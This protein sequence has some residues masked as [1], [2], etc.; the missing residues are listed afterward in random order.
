MPTPGWKN[1][2]R[3]SQLPPDWPKRREQV[4]K[5]DRACVKCGAPGTDVDHI[6]PGDDH[7]LGNLR[8]LCAACHKEKSSAEGGA[9][10]AAKRRAIERRLRR[11]EKHPGLL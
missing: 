11:T 10:Y 5:R 8:L 1:S 7:S 6:I 9:A 2:N 4:K 3:R